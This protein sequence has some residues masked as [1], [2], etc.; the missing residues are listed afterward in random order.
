MKSVTIFRKA[1]KEELQDILQPSHDQIYRVVNNLLKA[2]VWEVAG[3]I[4][5]PSPPSI[6]QIRLEELREP[7]HR[8]GYRKRHKPI[9]YALWN[10]INSMQE[11]LKYLSQ[12]TTVPKFGSFGDIANNLMESTSDNTTVSYGYISSSTKRIKEIHHLIYFKIEEKLEKELLKDET[13]SKFVSTVEKTCRYEIIDPINT[14]EYYLHKKKDKEIPEWEKL[15]LDVKFYDED[16]DAKISKG[17]K[18][19]E[20]IDNEIDKLFREITINPER[21]NEIKRQFYLKLLP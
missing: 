2:I 7:R 8:A 13:L 19:R 16:L 14:T 9:D 21:L 20:L 1:I 3:R 5:L 18:L 17:E 15:L 6:F 12:G 11:E 10:Q 4:K